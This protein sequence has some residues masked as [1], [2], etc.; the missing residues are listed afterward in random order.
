MDLGNS[1]RGAEERTKG[2]WRRGVAPILGEGI[3]AE[4]EY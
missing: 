4:I 2:L 1:A 3:I